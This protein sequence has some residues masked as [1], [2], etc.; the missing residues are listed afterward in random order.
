MGVKPKMANPYRLS[1]FLQ[2]AARD[3]SGMAATEFALLLPILTV[4][5]FGILELSEGMTANRRVAVAVNTAADL[6]AQSLQLSP[7]E[8]DGLMESVIPILEP[9]TVD[10]VDINLVSII[11]DADGDPV[12]HWSLHWNQDVKPTPPYVA[13]EDY[14]KLTSDFTT[15][16]NGLT[17][18]QNRSMIIVEMSY[19]Y[20]PQFAKYFVSDPIPFN[21]DAKRAPRRVTRV[22]LCD[23]SGNNC[24]T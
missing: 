20:A 21:R 8:V 15:S 16:P 2:R 19:P 4:L 13:G 11:L 9:A 6:A 7:D 24:T 23:N 17:R 14:T 12:V 22:Q 1:A 3:R 18:L 5:F 10:A